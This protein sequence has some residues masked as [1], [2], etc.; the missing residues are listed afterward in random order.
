MRLL[1]YTTQYFALLLLGVITVWAV[2]FYY[3]MLDEIYDSLDDGL[4][5][6]KILLLKRA[7]EDPSI[8]AHNDF[9]KHVYSFTP[10]SAPSFEQQQ[11]RYQDTLMYMLNEEDYEPVRIYESAIQANGGYYKLKIITSMVE[12]DDLIED[13]VSYLIGLYAFLVLCILILNNLLLKRIWKPFHY[14]IDQ[15]KDFKLDRKT[16][17][18]TAPTKIEEFTLLNTTVTTLI[19]STQRSS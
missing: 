16:S 15:L 12:E 19:A 8:L 4:E 14:L 9:D 6:Q 2:A 18:T 3:A 17:L 11:E 13:L 1:N 10:I 7:Q 5:N